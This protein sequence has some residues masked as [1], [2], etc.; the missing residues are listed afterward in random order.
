MAGVRLVSFHDLRRLL[1]RRCAE[2][3][4]TKEER[5]TLEMLRFQDKNFDVECI[6]VL[7]EDVPEPQDR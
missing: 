6:L 4:C 3:D 1:L 5:Y 7:G 2:N